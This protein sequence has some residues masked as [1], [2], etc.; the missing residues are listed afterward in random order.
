MDLAVLEE[1]R[2]LSGHGQLDSLSQTLQQLVQ[3]VSAHVEEVQRAVET[4]DG[5]A[6]AR[7]AHGLKGICGNM[8]ATAMAER[9]FSLEQQALSTTLEGAKAQLPL[10]RNDFH[11]VRLALEQKLVKAH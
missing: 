6:L 1:W 5:P 11:K 8:G 7:A 4:N 9:A 2:T 3:D 10:L